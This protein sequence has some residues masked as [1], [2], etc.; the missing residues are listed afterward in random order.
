MATIPPLQ[1]QYHLAAVSCPTNLGTCLLLPTRSTSRCWPT[2]LQPCHEVWSCSNPPAGRSCSC[3]HPCN[4]H[5]VCCRAKGVELRPASNGGPASSGAGLG[6]RPI[7][8][9]YHSFS[10]PSSPK[11]EAPPPSPPPQQLKPLA[12]SSSLDFIV[13]TD[14]CWMDVVRR[15]PSGVPTPGSLKAWQLCNVFTVRADN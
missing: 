13:V 7:Y 4:M 3:T 2:C 12:I 8:P 6:L 9:A 15:H 14:F 10:H 5:D 1:S 11:I